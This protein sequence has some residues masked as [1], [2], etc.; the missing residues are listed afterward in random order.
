[1]LLA[2]FT[3]EQHHLISSQRLNV[4][5]V[6]PGEGASHS[7]T[8]SPS[9]LSYTSFVYRATITWA[10]KTLRKSILSE[11]WLSQHAQQHSQALRALEESEVI[12]L[13]G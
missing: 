1:M 11:P 7:V 13:N 12:N 5:T 6:L 4:T 10:N 3:V 2:V 9:S 8:T